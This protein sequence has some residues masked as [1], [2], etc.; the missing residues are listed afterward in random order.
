M[1]SRLDVGRVTFAAQIV[2]K[3][4]QA[5]LIELGRKLLEFIGEL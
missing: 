4:D 2:D 1:K 3:L 5:L